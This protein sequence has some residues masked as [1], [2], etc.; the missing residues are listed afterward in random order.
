MW[1]WLWRFGGATANLMSGSGVTCA[2]SSNG[3]CRPP[4]LGALVW[5]GC[6]RPGC[7]TALPVRGLRRHWKR[8]RKPIPGKV[9]L[10]VGCG[11]AAVTGARSSWVGV[12][13]RPRMA[14]QCSALWRPAGW[15]LSPWLSSSSAACV[16]SGTFASV[17]SG[18]RLDSPP[19]TRF[20]RGWARGGGSRPA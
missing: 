17:A 1:R 19:R 12:T 15:V 2:E 3:T 11:R 16:S 14:S 8:R 4:R 10:R 9:A 6:W 20:R 18:N 7:A 5:P 13:L